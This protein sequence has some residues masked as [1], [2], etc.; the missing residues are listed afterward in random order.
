MKRYRFPISAPSAVGRQVPLADADARHIGKVLRLSPGDRIFLFDGDGA[1]YE[2]VIDVVAAD[3]VTASVISSAMPLRESPVHIAAAQAFLKEKKMDTVVRQLTEL[4]VDAWIPFPAERSVARPD[5]HKLASRAERWGKISVEAAKQCR[6]LK[7]PEIDPASGLDDVVARA[8]GFDAKIAFWEEASVEAV[9][10]SPET[11]PKSVF[12]LTGPEGGLTDTE[13]DRLKAAG[14]AAVSLGPRILRAET[15]AVVA[16]TLA[17][18]RYGDLG[19]L[20]A[21]GKP[22]GWEAKG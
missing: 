13:I 4:G 8:D 2:A 22:E 18:H 12:V 10:P 16:C 1:E 21:A 9:W 17:Q 5:R 3:T 19:A 11:T 6:R 20:R 15:A 7:I 14:F